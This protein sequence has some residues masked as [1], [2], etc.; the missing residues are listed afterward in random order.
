MALSL[1]HPQLEREYR[2]I[3]VK[4]TLDWSCPLERD[5]GAFSRTEEDLE[6]LD[7]GEE[8]FPS[9]WKVVIMLLFLQTILTYGLLTTV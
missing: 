5:N 7:R 8:V 3:W 6:R 9:G 2:K 1:A 4:G